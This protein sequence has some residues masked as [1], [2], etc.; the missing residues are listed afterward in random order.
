[1]TSSTRFTPRGVF[2]MELM[3]GLSVIM[4]ALTIGLFAYEQSVLAR[5]ARGT[6]DAA[7]ELVSISLE[8]VR[9]IDAAALPKPGAA[10][11]LGVPAYLQSQ[12]A[13]A[14]CSLN[15]SDGPAPELKRIHVAV[16][17]KGLAHPEMGE[18]LIR[19]PGGT[20]AKP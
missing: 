11:D 8:R 17:C 18:E 10:L 3:V 7:R 15:V 19:I 20:E 14:T 6:R 16:V 9:A 5:R 12:L 1:M 2:M 13:G 4:I